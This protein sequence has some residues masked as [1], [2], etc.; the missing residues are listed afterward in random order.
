[1][2]ARPHLNDRLWVRLINPDTKVPVTEDIEIS[3]D[4]LSID[5]WSWYLPPVSGPMEIFMQITLNQ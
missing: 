5:E 3:P 2:L 1:M 4:N